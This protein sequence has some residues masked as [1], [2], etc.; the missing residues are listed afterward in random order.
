MAYGAYLGVLIQAKYFHSLNWP[1]MLKTS[2][3]KFL[4]RFVIMIVLAAPF[5]CIYLL[6]PADAN[7]SL[8]IVFKTV[9]PLFLSLLSMFA[10]SNY[11]FA[12]FNL[13]NESK[14]GLLPIDERLKLL[15]HE[16]ES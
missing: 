2:F 13:V 10:Q 15:D 4:I 12:R 5:A 1:H 16:R 8:M 3:L 7:L 11:F 9:V 14:A 6:V